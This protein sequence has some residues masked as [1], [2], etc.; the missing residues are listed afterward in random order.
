MVISVDIL[1]GDAGGTGRCSVGVNDLLDEA[2]AG[3][4]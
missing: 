1:H 2:G 3:G 4:I